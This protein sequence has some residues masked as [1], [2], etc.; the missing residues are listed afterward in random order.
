M[1]MDNGAAEYADHEVQVLGKKVNVSSD[2]GEGFDETQNVNEGETIFEFQPVSDRGLDSDELAELVGF[3]RVVKTRIQGAGANDVNSEANAEGSL[4]INLGFGDLPNR[5]VTNG[6][7][8][9]DSSELS[10]DEI[11]GRVG[12]LNLNEPGVL[13][14]WAQSTNVGFSD[15]ASGVG[16]SSQNSTPNERQMFFPD[17]LGSGPYVDRTDDMTLQLELEIADFTI[18]VAY[19]IE[20]TYILYWEIHEM[21]EGRASFARP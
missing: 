9:T 13:D 8:V 17:T 3:Y 11:I 19:E 4:G 7:D 12:A 14:T 20:V 2:L 10:G 16:G 18:D 6:E 21:P 5:T 15:P 1:N